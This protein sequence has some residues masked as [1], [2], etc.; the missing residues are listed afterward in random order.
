MGRTMMAAVGTAMLV[1]LGGCAS[2][3]D[4]G[5]EA[6][7]ITTS[8]TASPEGEATAPGPVPDPASVG[9]T[10]IDI[11]VQG[12]Q[13][14]PLAERVK[15]EVGVSVTFQVVSD[16]P[17]E[18]HV[19]SEPEQTLEFQDGETALKVTIERPGVVDVEEHETGK[20]I[21]QLEVR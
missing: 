17:G 1:M 12:A 3:T 7:T 8:G 16:R 19:H 11:E 15:V 2:D 4:S 18:L 13:I 10:V 20:L 9:G 5:G 21:V 6:P 14:R